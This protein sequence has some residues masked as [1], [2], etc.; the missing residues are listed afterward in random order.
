MVCII[1]SNLHL[2]NS[3]FFFNLYNSNFLNNNASANVML[4]ICF[5]TYFMIGGST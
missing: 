5:E 1:K 2:K 3:L 4:R